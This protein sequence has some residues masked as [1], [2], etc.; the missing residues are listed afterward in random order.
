MSDDHHATESEREIDQLVAAHLDDALNAESAGRLH[1][2]LRADVQARRL[3]LAA[4]C[5][6]SALPRIALE[7]G[8]ARAAPAP[9][10]RR[11]FGVRVASAASW[12]AVASLLL[13]PLWWW[14]APTAART[15]RID[16]AAGLMIER[17]GQ[18]R[19]G[20]NPWLRAGDRITATGGPARLSWTT[21]GTSIELASGAQALIQTLGASKRLRLERGALH[22][23]VAPQP[24]G[25]G[26][27]VITPFGVVDVIGTRFSVQVS[28]HVSTV[29]VEHGSVRVSAAVAKASGSA[30]IAPVTLAA[31]YAVTLDGTTVSAPGPISDLPPSTAI[32]QTTFTGRMRLSAVD[33]HTDGGWEGDLVDGTIRGRPV[34]NSA[35]TRIT[36]PLGRPD[37]YARF[38]QDLRCTLRLSVDRPTTLAVLL[39]C[40]HPDGGSAWVGNLQ[41][42][43]RIQAGEQELTIAAADLRQVL[44]GATPPTGSRVVAA[45]VMSWS[46]A[47]D[48]RLQWIEFSR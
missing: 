7:S 5:Q 38:G 44:G 37:G 31:G 22:A 11:L 12:L 33:Y 14:L 25:G 10:R 13:A 19:D 39:V 43:R 30:G 35:V 46:G 2:L 23:V 8:L 45:A 21:E 29:A 1:D 40:D 17:A 47:A 9:R 20:T 16:G 18:Q 4:S 6:A 27:T 48:L 28:D 3:L 24:A 15:V 42:E 26:L 41:S 32:T 36:T 34:A